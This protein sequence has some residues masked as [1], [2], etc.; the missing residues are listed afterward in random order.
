MSKKSFLEMYQEFIVEM[1]KGEGTAKS[2]VSYL[3]GA[4][5][6][7]PEIEDNAIDNIADMT[8]DVQEIFCENLMRAITSAQKNNNTS[9]SNKTLDNYHSAVNMLIAFINSNN[10][11]ANTKPVVDKL[12]LSGEE[13]YY[14]K[15]DI[16]KNFLARLK[17]Q[18]RF[19]NEFGCFPI[20]LINKIATANGKKKLF[21]KLI[22]NT[23][24]IYSLTD[25]EDSQLRIIHL[26]DIDG[27]Y[28]KNNKAYVSINKK[29]Y[30]IFT[31]EYTDGK[32]SGYVVAT[33]NTFGDL[34]L[35]HD[36]PMFTALSGFFYRGATTFEQLSVSA[37]KYVNK[38]QWSN[39]KRANNLSKEYLHSQE[40][41]DLKLSEESLLNEVS[42]F[43]N[44]LS[45]T[46]MQ[47]SFNSSKNKN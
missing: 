38:K 32:K 5:K 43:I 30:P 17:T 44:T 7:L 41:K 13:S 37:L 27:V 31:E 28:I 3:N 35:D 2:Y 22:N 18:D 47:R 15:E 46:V 36:T 40:Y 39:K 19:Y 8:Q 29:N 6:N 12:P 26:K 25:G 9:V 45:L 4:C 33:V 14:S 20:R 24:F 34:S 16:K 21:D 1:G 42:A 10:A 11:P 23:S